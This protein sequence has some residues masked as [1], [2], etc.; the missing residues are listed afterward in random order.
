MKRR[1]EAI[2]I[3]AT[4]PA[5]ERTAADGPALYP[6]RLR[7][8]REVV[9]DN[10]VGGVGR[11]VGRVGAAPFVGTAHEGGAE[12]ASLRR[13]EVGIVAGDH[14]AFGRVELQEAGAGP[15]GF[16]QGLVLADRLAGDHRVPG[17]AVEPRRV[18]DDAEAEDGE[19]GAD[20]FRAQLRQHRR[21]VGPA[22]K[23]V[24]RVPPDGAAIL[25]RE[26]VEPVLGD[27]VVQRHAVRVVE[28]AVGRR[29]LAQPAHAAERTAP[30]LVGEVGPVALQPVP[31]PGFGQRRAEPGVPVEDGAA[32]IEGQR[33]QGVGGHDS[34]VCQW[35]KSR[36]RGIVGKR[37]IFSWW[38]LMP[39]AVCRHWLS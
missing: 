19:G 8:R 36:W 11:A 16:G 18:D 26:G 12:A 24:R 6:Q 17:Q 31:G 14:H 15:V 28:V 3:G 33:L 21:E 29:V 27:H 38:K 13:V 25:G 2:A 30:D 37:Q 4:P 20:V 34:R 1:H 9:H 7:Q 39:W 23:A 32:G 35:G 22:A 5:T 10:V